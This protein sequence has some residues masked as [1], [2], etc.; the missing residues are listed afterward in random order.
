M[1]QCL[2][3][4]AGRTGA[5]ARALP[6]L[7]TAHLATRSQKVNRECARVPAN[8]YDARDEGR[9][10]V[11]NSVWGWARGCAGAGAGEGGFAPRQEGASGGEHQGRDCTEAGGTAAI[12]SG[13]KSCALCCRSGAINGP[14]AASMQP[15]THSAG[16]R[17][18]CS[19]SRG[20]AQRHE[21][22]SACSCFS[23]H[24]SGPAC[25]GG[26]TGTSAA[27]TFAPASSGQAHANAG[28]QRTAGLQR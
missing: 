23:A 22:G 3:C 28:R 19:V 21:N 18:R 20:R 9:Q 6:A 17:W 4:A 27:A 1:Y 14:A 15:R 8:E 25:R 16:A 24:C 7:A 10:E 11:I 2:A 13:R 12:E 5:G 26:P